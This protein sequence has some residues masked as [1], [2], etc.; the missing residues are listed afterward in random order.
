MREGAGEV[1]SCAAEGASA[2]SPPAKGAYDEPHVDSTSRSHAIAR[3]WIAG[4]SDPHV[5][6]ESA[7]AHQRHGDRA[8]DVAPCFSTPPPP[9]ALAAVTAPPPAPAPP[10][11]PPKPSSP[12]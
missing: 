6:K 10:T 2:T 8:R 9:P 4:P 7:G 3:S 1:L 5:V 12:R 11:P